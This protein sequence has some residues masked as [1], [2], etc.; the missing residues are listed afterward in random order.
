MWNMLKLKVL[1]FDTKIISPQNCFLTFED[2]T[3]KPV[4]KGTTIN[5]YITNLSVKSSLIKGKLL[6][7]VTFSGSLEWPLYTSLTVPCNFNLK[8]RRIFVHELFDEKFQSKR[9]VTPSKMIWSNCHDMWLYTIN[10][11]AQHWALS[12]LIVRGVRHTNI[13]MKYSRQKGEITLTNMVWSNCY[14][15]MHILILL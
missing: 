12:N 14:I 3:V 7:K 10:K 11:H 2:Y 1:T 8:C 9:V 5:D 15:H 4:L 13:L 6:I